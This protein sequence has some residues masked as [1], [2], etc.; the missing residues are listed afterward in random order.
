MELDSLINLATLVLTVGTGAKMMQK[1][2]LQCNAGDSVLGACFVV[3]SR[4]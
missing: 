1:M 4:A 2:F 3:I